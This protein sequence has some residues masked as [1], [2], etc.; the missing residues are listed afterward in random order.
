[1]DAASSLGENIAFD[2]SLVILEP[3][4]TLQLVMHH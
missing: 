2:A 3:T 1:M 4:V